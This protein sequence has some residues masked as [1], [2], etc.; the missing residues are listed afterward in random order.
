MV[1]VVEDNQ[2]C[3]PQYWVVEWRLLRILQGAESNSEVVYQA[4][5]E[6][7]RTGRTVVLERKSI[8][9]EFEVFVE[10]LLIAPE[11]KL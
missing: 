1:Q 11:S 2:D 7:R 3:L 9:I 6:A 4:F 10:D 5:N 8:E